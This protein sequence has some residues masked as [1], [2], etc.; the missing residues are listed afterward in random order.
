MERW[1]ICT[2]SK[3]VRR[4]YNL[5]GGS[6]EKITSSPSLRLYLWAGT[7]Y[8]WLRLWILKMAQALHTLLVNPRP[9]CASIEDLKESSRN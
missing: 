5:R 3:A 2:L 7:A 1:A 6:V 4:N 9:E 8:S